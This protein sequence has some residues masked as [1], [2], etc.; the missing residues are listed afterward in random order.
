MC[1]HQQHTQED[2]ARF[3][4]DQATANQGTF[5]PYMHRKQGVYARPLFGESAPNE[6]YEAK[7]IEHHGDSNPPLFAFQNKPNWHPAVA[8]LALGDR[9]AWD[10]GTVHRIEKEAFDEEHT[11][12]RY[13]KICSEPE[14]Q[15]EEIDCECANKMSP[16][17]M[18]NLSHGMALSTTSALRSGA[19]WRRV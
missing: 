12:C 7:V 17:K 5:V 13:W 4:I 1:L 15:Q 9:L 11:C 8:T 16:A 3:V 2:L 14:C 10:T 18:C 19:V 6:P